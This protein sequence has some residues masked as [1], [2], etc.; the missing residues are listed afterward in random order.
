MVILNSVGKM[1][2]EKQVE[3]EIREAYIFLREH[4][5]TV[6]SE[7]LQFMLEAS[8]EKLNKVSVSRDELVGTSQRAYNSA[9]E[10]VGFSKIQFGDWFEKL[11]V[12]K[13]IEFHSEEE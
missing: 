13:K 6:P 8:L 2:A 9:L 1:S 4:N 11:I 5:Y 12:D 10:S 7:T 3:K